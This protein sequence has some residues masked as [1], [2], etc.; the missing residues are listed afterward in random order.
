MLAVNANIDFVVHE[1]LKKCE[2]KST[3]RVDLRDTAMVEIFHENRD[4]DEIRN[5]GEMYNSMLEL[6][7]VRK[8]VDKKAQKRRK[9]YAR[10]IYFE[11]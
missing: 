5:R 3:V 11:R 9:W 1:K 10:G 8:L 6:H 7:V 4:E 2:R